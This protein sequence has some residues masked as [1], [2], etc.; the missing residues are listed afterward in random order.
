MVERAY[1]VLDLVQPC[2]ADGPSGDEAERQGH[3]RAL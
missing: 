3:S 1:A 2:L